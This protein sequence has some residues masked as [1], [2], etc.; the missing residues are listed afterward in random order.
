M[1]RLTTVSRS[2]HEFTLEVLL[3]YRNR[4]AIYI[5]KLYTLVAKL[6]TLVAS[7]S[8][9]NGTYIY[10]YYYY[11]SQEIVNCIYIEHRLFSIRTVYYAKKTLKASSLYNF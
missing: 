8:Y 5:A 7:Y 11:C 6:Y 3:L 9:N 2:Y 4:L 1:Q 10:S